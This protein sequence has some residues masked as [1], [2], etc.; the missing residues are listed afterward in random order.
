MAANA[1][2]N[3]VSKEQL[4]LSKSEALALLY[5]QK[6]DLTGVTPEELVNRFVETHDAIKKEFNRQ[7]EIRTRWLNPLPM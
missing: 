2:A 5:L 1:G 4:P 6:Q 7:K 3:S